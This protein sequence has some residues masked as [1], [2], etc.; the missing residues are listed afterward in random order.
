MSDLRVLLISP[1]RG[2]DPDNGDLTYTEQLRHRPPPSITYTT[3]D[4]ALADGSLVEL[5]RRAA[6]GGR[7]RRDA[8]A[9]RGLSVVEL[10][11]FG[12]EA[13]VNRFRSRGVLFPEPFRHF[14]VEPS[15]FDLIHVHVFSVAL[16]CADLPIVVSNS[17]PIH[18]VY[19]DGRRSA[20]RVRIQRVQ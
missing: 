6:G 1:V 8:S 10:A 20:G 15:A 5:Y 3:Y 16:N 17:A 19:E 11:R 12:R 18:A 4:R 9:F 7:D 14:N 2:L 13:A